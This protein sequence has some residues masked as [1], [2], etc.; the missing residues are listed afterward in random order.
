MLHKNLMKE[1]C[2]MRRIEELQEQ[3]SQREIYIIENKIDDSTKSLY[4]EYVTQGICKRSITDE[5]SN[6][7]RQRFNEGWVCDDALSY[8]EDYNDIMNEYKRKVQDYPWSKYRIVKANC[9]CHESYGIALTDFNYERLEIL[10]ITQ[11]LKTFLLIQR[12]IPFRKLREY[13]VNRMIN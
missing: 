5:V 12:C 10:P 11:T 13:L 2:K 3:E 8:S 9:V 6:N 4:I 1:G 7:L